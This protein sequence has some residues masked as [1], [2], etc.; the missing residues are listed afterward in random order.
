MPQGSENAGDHATAEA[1]RQ[2]SVRE[3]EDREKNGLGGGRTEAV[4][5][6]RSGEDRCGERRQTRMSLALL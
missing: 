5:K 2:Q 1:V 3:R 4:R 6:K